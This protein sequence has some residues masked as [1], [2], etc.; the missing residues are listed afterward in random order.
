MLARIQRAR[1]TSSAPFRARAVAHEV[2]FNECSS[3]RSSLRGALTACVGSPAATFWQLRTRRAWPQSGVTGP[4]TPS[5]RQ[6]H[7]PLLFPRPS[8]QGVHD[9]DGVE[10]AG[11][12]EARTMAVCTAAD[13]LQD[14][15]GRFWSA[16]DWRTWVTDE[17]GGTICT[18]RFTAE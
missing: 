3:L 7:A 6:C 15:G 9:H 2:D 14:L 13:V 12:D 18:L 5:S 8:R 17:R 16:P 4:S 11:D 1:K 10:L